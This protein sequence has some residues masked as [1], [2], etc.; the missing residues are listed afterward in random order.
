MIYEQDEIFK[1]IQQCNLNKNKSDSHVFNAKTK[2]GTVWVDCRGYEVYIRH[3][4]AE[5]DTSEWCGTA[6]AAASRLERLGI[7][8]NTVKMQKGGAENKGL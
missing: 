7:D 3:M 8:I 6:V 5:E 1:L 4:V 2:K